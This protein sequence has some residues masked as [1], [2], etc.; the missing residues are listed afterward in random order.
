M[1]AI[2]I[3][4]RKEKTHS[5]IPTSAEKRNVVKRVLIR[6][7]SILSDRVRTTLGIPHYLDRIESQKVGVLVP[8][9]LNH[10]VAFWRGVVAFG[11]E[12]FFDVWIDA[13]ANDAD[14]VAK[15]GGEADTTGQDKPAFATIHSA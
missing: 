5:S 10:R 12:G 2:S 9:P 6:G 4:S 14:Q 15:A 3:S 13:V 11:E 1:E 7:K 8:P